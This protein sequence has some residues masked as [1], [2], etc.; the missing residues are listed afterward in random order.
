MRSSFLLP[1]Q[2]VIGT[3]TRDNSDRPGSFEVRRVVAGVVHPDYSKS[4][5]ANDIGLLLLDQPSSY[6]PIALA[7]HK[8]EQLELPGQRLA[9]WLAVRAPM[10]CKP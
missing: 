1:S 7:P 3:L 10:P 8:R 4:L 5:H 2:V 6:R 9:A